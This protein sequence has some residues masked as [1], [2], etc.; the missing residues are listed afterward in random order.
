MKTYDLTPK[1]ADRIDELQGQVNELTELVSDLEKN[2]MALSLDNK[3]IME[4][5]NEIYGKVK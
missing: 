1:D 3:R 5:L 4:V 2:L